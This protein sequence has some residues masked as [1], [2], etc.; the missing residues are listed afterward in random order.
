MSKIE[1]RL[2]LRISHIVY[3]RETVGNRVKYL[4]DPRGNGT[5]KAIPETVVL[6]R[7]RRRQFSGC[8]FEGTRLSSTLWRSV[9]SAFRESAKTICSLDRMQI[10]AIVEKEHSTLKQQFLV[11]PNAAALH[12]IFSVLGPKRLELLISRHIAP[13]WAAHSGVPDL[14]FFAINL[15]TR[16]PSIARFVEVKK[17][18]EVVSKD[19]LAEIDFLNSLGLHARVLRLIE[20]N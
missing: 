16:M 17:P 7:W 12:A 9:H 6:K 19:Q 20:R 13:E 5:E 18:D 14:F 2:A 1:Q 4:V 3:G 11:L 15:A 8:A 10:E